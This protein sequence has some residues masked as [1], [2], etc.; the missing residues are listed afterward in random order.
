MGKDIKLLLVTFGFSALLIVGFL[1][2]QVGLSGANGDSINNV[3]IEGVEASP[4]TYDLGM[5]Q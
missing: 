4:E 1:L 5:Y 2:L 3:P